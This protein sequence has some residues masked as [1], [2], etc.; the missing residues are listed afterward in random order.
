MEWIGLQWALVTYC[1]VP[2]KWRCTLLVFRKQNNIKLMRNLTYSW[3]SPKIIENIQVNIQVNMLIRTLSDYL[4]HH[5]N[6]PTKKTE[7]IDKIWPKSGIFH[8][9]KVTD[10]VFINRS[11]Y[12]IKWMSIAPVLSKLIYVTWHAIWFL[13]RELGSQFSYY[14]LL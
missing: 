14:Y 9:S 13:C 3:F 2:N 10:D 4:E 11:R 12:E 1:G 5:S 6:W 8:F 7:A